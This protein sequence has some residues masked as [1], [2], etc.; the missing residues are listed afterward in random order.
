MMNK[1]LLISIATGL[2]ANAVT[3]LIR[4]VHADTDSYLSQIATDMHALARGGRGC[5]NSKICD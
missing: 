5:L 4:P 2:W 1:L 3:T